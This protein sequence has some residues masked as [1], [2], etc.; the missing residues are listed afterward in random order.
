MAK[1]FKYQWNEKKFVVN[2][3]LVSMVG[4]FFGMRALKF[5]P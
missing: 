1:F 5:N 2:F 3:E 4:I